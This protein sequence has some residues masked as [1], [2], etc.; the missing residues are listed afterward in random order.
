MFTVVNISKL[1]PN[2]WEKKLNR[3][4]SW[5][6][7]NFISVYW[8]FRSAE[9]E[10]HYF[11][12]IVFGFQNI[13]ATSPPIRD[14]ARIKIFAFLKNVNSMKKNQKKICRV[15]D[16]IGG[17]AINLNHFLFRILFEF[18]VSNQDLRLID[19]SSNRSR[20]SANCYQRGRSQKTYWFMPDRSN[21][22]LIIFK[23][24]APGSEWTG[25]SMWHTN[26]YSINWNI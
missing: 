14:C 5:K 1:Y 24:C 8:K 23:K 25:V 26:K 19:Q 11:L 7:M 13:R 10:H 22:S 18:S 21:W 20:I 12:W 2:L 4:S 17:C 15:T 6:M 3:K 16:I 9:F